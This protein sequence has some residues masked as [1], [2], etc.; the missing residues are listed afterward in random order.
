M[1]LLGRLRGP[2][3]RPAIHEVP[4]NLYRQTSSITNEALKR[5]R[6]PTPII[7]NLNH[8]KI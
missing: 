8:S 5:S 3:I 4:A 6:T 1:H 7:R 2:I